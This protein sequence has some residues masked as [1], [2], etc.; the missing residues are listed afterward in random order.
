M[1]TSPGWKRPS[2]VKLKQ[3][4]RSS[5]PNA[6]RIVKDLNIETGSGASQEPQKALTVKRRNPFEK[7]KD[8]NRKYVEMEVIQ[9]CFTFSYNCVIVN[10]IQHD[11]IASV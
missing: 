10:V 4:R 1:D 2:L 7:D 3:K 11:F 9:I 8:D 5:L 6:K